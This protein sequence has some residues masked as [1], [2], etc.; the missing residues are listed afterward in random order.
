MTKHDKAKAYLQRQGF[1]FDP[2]FERNWYP[3]IVKA[4]QAK[5]ENG[6]LLEGHLTKNVL[7]IVN[8]RSRVSVREFLQSCIIRAAKKLSVAACVRRWNTGKNIRYAIVHGKPLERYMIPPSDSWSPTDEITEGGTLS[9]RNPS[10]QVELA[11]LRTEALH[12]SDDELH[13]DETDSVLSVSQPDG[14]TLQSPDSWD[15]DDQDE[16]TLEDFLGSPSTQNSASVCSDQVETLRSG[17]QVPESIEA[18]AAS[19]PG[20]EWIERQERRW[21]GNL[22]DTH[23]DLILRVTSESARLAIAVSEEETKAILAWNLLN[24]PGIVVARHEEHGC[25]C[26]LSTSRMKETSPGCVFAEKLDQIEVIV[27]GV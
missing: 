11:Q 16:S 19:L 6:S 9:E 12:E 5:G 4:I 24:W 18:I 21:K 25:Y 27:D 20:S 22:A 17:D 26:H 3:S 14:D 10:I 2:T 8:Y 7:S 15:S 1:P 23:R 13:Q